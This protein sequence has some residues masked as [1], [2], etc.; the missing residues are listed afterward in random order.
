MSI[1]IIIRVT[2]QAVRD[3]TNTVMLPKMVSATTAIV[4]MNMVILEE[5]KILETGARTGHLRDTKYGSGT[6]MWDR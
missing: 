4:E 3:K 1:I 2:Y 6:Y 5:N